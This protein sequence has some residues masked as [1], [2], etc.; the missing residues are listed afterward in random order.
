M[1]PKLRVTAALLFVDGKLLCARRAPGRSQAGLWEFPGGKIEPGETDEACLKRELHEELK[2]TANIG[3]KFA[4]NEHEYDD[5]I[6]ELRAYWVEMY[7]GRLEPSDHDKIRWLTV[8]Q[9]D[10]LTWAPADIP[11][12]EQLMHEF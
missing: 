9:L 1:K 8:D 12:V 7:T 5:K 3:E 2:I 4:V 10:T 11:F 6:V